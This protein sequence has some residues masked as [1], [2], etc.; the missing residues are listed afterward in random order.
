MLL[1][2]TAARMALA[3]AAAGGLAL[4]AGGEGP[5]T[6]SG[7]VYR[8]TL[9]SPWERQLAVDLC[10]EEATP[11]AEAHFSRGDGEWLRL[12]VDPPGPSTGADVT[13]HAH[14][15]LDGRL[16]PDGPL[17]AGRRRV[18]SITARAD[19]HDYL[20]VQGSGSDEDLPVADLTA[21]LDGLRL[22]ANAA[23]ADCVARR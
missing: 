4:E 1:N 19:G 13:V 10:G 20:L 15:E 6:F 23:P 8:L 16:A 18:V 22:V 9:P 5:H 7:T 14:V 21:V 2:T 17:A 3:L 11:V 12:V